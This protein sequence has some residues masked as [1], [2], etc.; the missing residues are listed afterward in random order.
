LRS[1]ALGQ[2][3][4]EGPYGLCYLIASP[5]KALE[6]RLMLSRNL[7][8]PSRAAMRQWLLEDLRLDEELLSE[9]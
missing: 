4:G 5:T 7:A 9:L 6:D 3:L 1:Y 2:Q 8:P